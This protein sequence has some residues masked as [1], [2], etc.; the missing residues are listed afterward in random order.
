ML[1]LIPGGNGDAAP[2]ERAANELAAWYT[3]VTYDR[4]GFSRSTLDAPP[5]DQRR[6]ETDSNDAIGLL[7]QLGAPTA[8]VLGSSSGAIVALDLITRHPERVRRPRGARA[9]SRHAAARR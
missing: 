3:V 1:L 5:D 4:R 6:L 2:F 8:Y 7:D 9:A